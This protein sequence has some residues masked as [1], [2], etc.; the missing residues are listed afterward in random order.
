MNVIITF[1]ERK[2]RLNRDERN[3]CI[4]IYNIVI[5]GTDKTISI[6][7]VDL[8]SEIKTFAKSLLIEFFPN[9]YK[10]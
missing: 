1:L 6:A 9:Q 4:F 3:N 7:F 8:K 5:L 10:F 2:N